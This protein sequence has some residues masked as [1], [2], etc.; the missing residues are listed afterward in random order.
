MISKKTKDRIEW[1]IVIGGII[2]GFGVL[3]MGMVPVVYFIKHL[4]GI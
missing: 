1:M 2:G 3:F 4:A